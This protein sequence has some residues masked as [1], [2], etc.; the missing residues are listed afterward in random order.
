[1]N[2]VILFIFSWLSICTSYLGAHNDGFEVKSQK[3]IPK[4][5][6]ITPE[7]CGTFLLCKAL[8]MITEKQSVHYFPRTVTDLEGFR[9]FLNN[10]HENHKF[11]FCHITPTPEVINLLKQEKYK[12]FFIVRDPRDQLISGM[13]MIRDG[14]PLAE[15]PP[16]QF[17]ALNQEEQIEELITGAL[18]HRPLYEICV[19]RQLPWLS[20]SKANVHASYFESLVGPEGGGERKLQV[21]EIMQLGKHFGIKLSRKNAKAI[22]KELF[23]GTW[24]FREGQIGGWRK[25]F[26]EHHIQLYKTKYSQ[27]LINLGYEENENWFFR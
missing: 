19:E 26:C 2:L 12:I 13:H 5:I 27:T 23:G 1:M 21:R 16:I 25:Y 22:A 17:A 15:I 20:V 8:F 11:V 18:F 6:V 24:S 7:K 3:E 4:F 10:A 14:H 9:S